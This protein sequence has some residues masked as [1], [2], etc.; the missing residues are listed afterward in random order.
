MMLIDNRG[1]KNMDKTSEKT[2][3]KQPL[4][5]QSLTEMT[6][7]NT[8]RRTLYHQQKLGATYHAYATNFQGYL[9]YN[10][11]GTRQLRLMKQ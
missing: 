5:L 7:K 10:A 1:I 9:L 11:D 4:Y 6:R 8:N 3:Q 2:K